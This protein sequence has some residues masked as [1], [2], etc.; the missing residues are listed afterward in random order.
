M[1]SGRLLP[2]FESKSTNSSNHQI[3]QVDVQYSLS[4]ER[5]FFL[6][7]HHLEPMHSR[8]C[9][10]AF[11]SLFWLQIYIFGFNHEQREMPFSN[12]LTLNYWSYQ[13]DMSVC[14]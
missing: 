13:D 2:I 11:K 10:S 9:S 4:R 14:A 12:G 6:T 5:F 1:T 3:I 7:F 8:T